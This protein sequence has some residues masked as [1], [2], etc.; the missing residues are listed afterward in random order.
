ME[1]S[2]SSSLSPLLLLLLQDKARTGLLSLLIMVLCGA[3]FT[4]TIFCVQVSVQE[5]S[6]GLPLGFIWK[7]LPNLFCTPCALHTLPDTL[8]S[9]FFRCVIMCDGCCFLCLLLLLLLNTHLSFRFWHQNRPI[10][11]LLGA[12]QH[13]S[14][15]DFSSSGNISTCSL[16]A[17]DQFSRTASLPANLHSIAA[18]APSWHKGL[19]AIM[20]SNR[21]AR[22]LWIKRHRPRHCQTLRCRERQTWRFGT[23]MNALRITTAASGT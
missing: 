2:L 21:Y 14:G 16:L 23:S 6:L 19:V 4:A 7:T 10:S 22:F 15:T 17:P 18:R 8:I 9:A 20:R 13:A 5:F 12:Y 3:P 1:F 11:W